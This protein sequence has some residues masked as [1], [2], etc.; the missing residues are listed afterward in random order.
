M[1]WI[2]KDISELQKSR[3]IGY[4]TQQR[5][6]LEVFITYVISD[7]FLRG[8]RD[9]WEK[10]KKKIGEEGAAAYIIVHVVK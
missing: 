5:D 1:L 7:S 3:Q 2:F 6:R 4:V 9:F 10:T 8:A